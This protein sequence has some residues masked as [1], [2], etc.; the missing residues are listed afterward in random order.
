MVVDR[1]LRGTRGTTWEGSDRASAKYY[2]YIMSK[3][4]LVSYLQFVLVNKTN[5]TY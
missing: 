4:I 1:V 5:A 2:A 3:F